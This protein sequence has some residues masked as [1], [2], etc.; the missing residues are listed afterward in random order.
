MTSNNQFCVR[1]NLGLSLID[2][3]TPSS[4]RLTCPNSIPS[5]LSSGSFNMSNVSLA[6]SSE[7][8]PVSCSS[9]SLGTYHTQV[10]PLCVHPPVITVEDTDDSP[11]FDKSKSF[12][13]HVQEGIALQK[14]LAS[15]TTLPIPIH[16][17]DS[18]T[19]VT[20]YFGGS[21]GY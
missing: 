17:Y 4:A 19:P 21:S 6:P 9:A 15:T 10:T 2:C 1:S 3:H 18:H 7:V 16:K 11:P 12:P 8:N 14:L 20:M 5:Q 13:L